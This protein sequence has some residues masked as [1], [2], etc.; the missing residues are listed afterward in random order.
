[1]A[2]FR[3]RTVAIV[4]HRLNHQ[5]HPAW[6]ITLVSDLFVIDTFFF[7]SATSN[8]AVDRVVGHVARLGVVDR[9]AQTRV[10]IRIAAAATSRDSDLFNKLREQFAALGIERAFLVLDTMPLRMSGH[11]GQILLGMWVVREGNISKTEKLSQR[12]V[13]FPRLHEY[14]QGLIG[15]FPERE[16]ILVRLACGGGVATDRGS[17]SQP[18]M[19]QRVRG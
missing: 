10:C 11:W 19:R 7:A 9:L 2:N 16:E 4:S 15:V 14:R 6:T 12:L 13:L 5:G 3:H 8:R 18:Q 17:T 1:M